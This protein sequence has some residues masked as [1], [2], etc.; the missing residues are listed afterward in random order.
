MNTYF[1]KELATVDRIASLTGLPFEWE[2]TGG[3]CSAAVAHVD[4][5]QI[6]VMDN[7]ASVP[8]E[9]SEGVTIGI[10]VGNDHETAHY[11]YMS[12]VEDACEWLKVWASWENVK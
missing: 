8:D 7:G 6:M 4:C 3:W 2:N 9:H 10:Y 12:T 1:E 5:Y 11:E